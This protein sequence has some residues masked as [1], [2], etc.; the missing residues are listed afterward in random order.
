MP[1]TATIQK[2][3]KP[4]AP[5]WASGLSAGPNSRSNGRSISSKPRRRIA[6][7][8]AITGAPLD[9]GEASGSCPHRAAPLA[10]QD[11]AEHQERE[12]RDHAAERQAVVD[13]ISPGAGV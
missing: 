9:H 4:S 2:K 8:R 12:R 10:Q 3:K 6:R 5:S 11:A 1:L 7:V 13:A